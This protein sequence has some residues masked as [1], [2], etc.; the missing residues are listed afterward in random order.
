MFYVVF[1]KFWHL[2]TR[3]QQSWLQI[4]ILRQKSCPEPAGNLANPESR[5]KDGQIVFLSVFY[6]IIRSKFQGW[7]IKIQFVFQCQWFK[8]VGTWS[9][10]VPIGFP[11][12]EPCLCFEPWRLRTFFCD[13]LDLHFGHLVTRWTELVCSTKGGFVTWTVFPTCRL[14]DARILE[15][16]S[17][18]RNLCKVSDREPD[19]EI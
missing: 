16:W 9:P 1:L 6:P 4:R 2:D 3:I 5:P 19:L 17:R 13:S 12:L 7:K 10:A 18:I 15:R 11:T 8:G 14:L